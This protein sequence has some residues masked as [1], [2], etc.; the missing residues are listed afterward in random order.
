MPFLWLSYGTI[1][2]S[3]K[4]HCQFGTAV[5]PAQKFLV[6]CIE[7]GWVGSRSA[8]PATQS[9]G[10]FVHQSVVWSTVDCCSGKSAL[11]RAPIQLHVID[12]FFVIR[13]TL[14]EFRDDAGCGILIYRTEQ[15]K[16]LSWRKTILF[17]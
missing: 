15:R 4:H 13:C 14:I 3:I 2:N 1:C 8:P 5:T 11:H 6:F 7:R 12:R 9:V 16:S 17:F 10:A